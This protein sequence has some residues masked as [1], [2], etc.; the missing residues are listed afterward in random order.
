MRQRKIWYCMVCVC[1]SYVFIRPYICIHVYF[2]SKRWGP[3]WDAASNLGQHRLRMFHLRLHLLT[4]TYVA[5]FMLWANGV[6]PDWAPHDVASDL[7]L[8]CLCMFQ[9][10]IREHAVLFC[11]QL[12]R[13]KQNMLNRCCYHIVRSYVEPLSCVAVQMFAFIVQCD[14]DIWRTVRYSIVVIIDKY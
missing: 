2:M 5:M 11:V 13:V 8:H 3:W 9:L 12:M 14:R 1:S 4:S 7:R 10:G 6:D